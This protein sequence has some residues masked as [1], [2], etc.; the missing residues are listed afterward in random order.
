[1][2]SILGFRNK[3]VIHYQPPHVYPEKQSLLL[4]CW[5][6][7]YRK[8]WE[9]SLGKQKSSLED[10]EQGHPLP[11]DKQE[12]QSWRLPPLSHATWYVGKTYSCIRKAP[13]TKKGSQHSSFFCFLYLINKSTIWSLNLN[14]S[15]I[16][17]LVHSK[18]YWII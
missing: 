10:L 6:S 12:P 7:A 3:F 17:G 5:Q 15:S 2:L 13:K 11:Q 1:M 4:T 16:I 9:F 14:L 18:W 8:T